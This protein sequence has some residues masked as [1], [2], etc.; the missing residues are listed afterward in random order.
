MCRDQTQFVG[1]GY[2]HF[3]K[4]QQHHKEAFGVHAIRAVLVETTDE[5]CGKKPMELVVHPLVAG[6]GKRAGLF[7]FSIT[8]LFTDPA[9]DSAIPSYLDRPEAIF[10]PIWAL[11]DHS[12]HALND[13]ENT[14]S[15]HSQAPARLT[16]SA[17][18]LT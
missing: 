1:C 13:A 7:W 16:D 6:P 11:P 5:A 3:I 4:K 8:P 15:A 12:L 10:E 9:A 14:H 2:H 18:R 17:S